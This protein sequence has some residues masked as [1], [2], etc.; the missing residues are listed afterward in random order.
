M[1]QLSFDEWKTQVNIIVI[2]LSGMECDD[3]PDFDY[4]QDYQDSIPPSQTAHNVVE[5]AQDY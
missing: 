5:D 3:L 4:Y 2:R 1:K